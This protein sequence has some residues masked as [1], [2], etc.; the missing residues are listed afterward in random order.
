VKVWNHHG[1]YR[2][3]VF[4]F[5][6][7]KSGCVSSSDCCQL[8][9]TFPVFQSSSTMLSSQCASSYPRTFLTY[10]LSEGARDKIFNI[11]KDGGSKDLESAFKTWADSR[12]SLP[13][14]NLLRSPRFR[15]SL[16]KGL[17]QDLSSE[18]IGAGHANFA[19]AMSMGCELVDEVNVLRKEVH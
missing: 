3:G 13:F 15:A 1:G 2:I 16:Q 7:D 14:K 18:R 4:T 19:A 5:V 9:L 8:L 12:D 10:P 17:N 6:G 11:P